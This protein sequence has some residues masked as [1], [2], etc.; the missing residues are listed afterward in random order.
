MTRQANESRDHHRAARVA[1]LAGALLVSAVA[2]AAAHDMFLR[3]DR[4]FVA[5]Q[6]DVVVRLLNG[7]FAL[8]E[9]AILRTRV[10]DATVAGPSGRIPIDMAT[11]TEAGDTTTFRVKVGAAGTYAIGV[12]TRPSVIDLTAE[13]FNAYLRDDGLPDVLQA[14]RTRRQL[15]QPAR[16]RY[17]KHV[18]ALLQVGEARGDSYASVFGYPAEI[19]PIDNPY[20][21]RVGATLRVR[22][23]VAG[24]PVANQYVLYGG[25][26]SRGDRIEPRGVRSTADGTAR[27]PIAS[28][29]IWYVK[30]IHMTRL[31]ADTVDYES[32]WATLTFEVR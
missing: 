12:S 31:A 13:E 7:T 14:R 16:E 15:D 3:A 32:S 11:W 9:N 27:I 19:V 10:R 20:S 25:R 18:K 8:S 26:T 23:Q 28:P 22:V 24:R 1:A 21:L 30:F 5:E 17:H 29:G 2:V 4:F 6:S